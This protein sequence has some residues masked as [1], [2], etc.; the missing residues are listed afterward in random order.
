MWNLATNKF[1]SYS[2]VSLCSPRPHRFGKP[3][4]SRDSVTSCDA[5][6][7]RG[8]R[9]PGITGCNTVGLGLLFVRNIESRFIAAVRSSL[10]YAEHSHTTLWFIR[11][12]GSC[13]PDHPVSASLRCQSNDTIESCGGDY[14]STVSFQSLVLVVGVWMWPLSVSFFGYLIDY[15]L[16]A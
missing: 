15:L 9:Y 14:W 5:L 6:R 12:S 16:Y 2:P 7:G 3:T 1:F 13:S 10:Y 4:G 8:N 11:V